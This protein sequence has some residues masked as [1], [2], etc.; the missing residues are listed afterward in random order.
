MASRWYQKDSRCINIWW[1]FQRFAIFGNPKIGPNELEAVFKFEMFLFSLNGLNKPSNLASLSHF[2]NR[3]KCVCRILS[4]RQ[5]GTVTLFL[6]SDH[7]L[8]FPWNL[9][10]C[11]HL[12]GYLLE[13][14][15]GLI[16]VWSLKSHPKIM[17]STPARWDW[18]RSNRKS[19]LSIWHCRS[20]GMSCRFGC[21]VLRC[22]VVPVGRG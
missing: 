11:C 4:S 6:K 21:E 7:F 10:E 22:D 3:M 5:V 2:F 9:R 18:M 8:T 16:M 19:F 14:I 17:L 12:L 13:L 1:W 20:L 15:Q